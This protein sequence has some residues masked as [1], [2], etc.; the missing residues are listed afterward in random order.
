MCSGT[1]V[2]SVMGF[3]YFYITS[4]FDSALTRTCIFFKGPIGIEN[5][6]ITNCSFEV[7]H[8]S[9]TMDDILDKGPDC[10]TVQDVVQTGNTVRCYSNACKAQAP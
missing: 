3:I 10:C 2:C 6:T 4:R 9:T 1:H 8:D 7:L 5:I